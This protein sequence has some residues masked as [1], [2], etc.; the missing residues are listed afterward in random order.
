MAKVLA[1]DHGEDRHLASHPNAKE[2]GKEEEHPGLRRSEEEQEREG[3]QAETARHNFFAPDAVR[4]DRY[5]KPRHHTARIH[6]GIDASG[7]GRREA[8]FHRDRRQKEQDAV[9]AHTAP[10]VDANE[11]PEGRRPRGVLV[12]GL[13]A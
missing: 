11:V 9:V 12:I 10:E 1:V 5:R 4:H 8:M 3:L 6:G 7:E 2:D 13:D